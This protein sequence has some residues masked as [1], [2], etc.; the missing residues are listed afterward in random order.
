MI[1]ENEIKKDYT[2]MYR[3]GI[4][5]MRSFTDLAAWLSVIF[6]AEGYVYGL[7]FKK[8]MVSVFL[9]GTVF[10]L[11]F[12]AR[13]NMVNMPALAVSHGLALAGIIFIAVLYD[14]FLRLF[15]YISPVMQFFIFIMIV[16][17]MAASI[18]LWRR[19]FK[20]K[21]YDSRLY[22]LV[23]PGILYTYGAYIARKDICLCGIIFACIMFLAH[24]WSKYFAGAGNVIGN[25]KGLKNVPKD[26]IHLKGRR[27]MTAITAGFLIMIFLAILVDFDYLVVIIGKYILKGIAWALYGMIWLFDKLAVFLS[28]FGID[29]SRYVTAL[30]RIGMRLR[31]G[32]GF[33]NLIM[34]I[35][36]VICI[37]FVLR[38]LL[39]EVTRYFRKSVDEV[40]VD[41]GR[42]S[43]VYQDDLIIDL[44]PPKEDNMSN[45]RTH[46]G[47]IRAM[48][49]KTIRSGFGTRV[50]PGEKTGRE[51]AHMITTDDKSA[52]DMSDIYDR[53][54][55][56]D[57]EMT[58]KDE[59][60]MAGAV[61][62]TRNH[63][64]SPNLD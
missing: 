11:L 30:E 36:G 15:M 27:G 58:G 50:V 47:R 43:V 22:L 8:M 63:R 54:R 17:S 56:G 40:S 53:A 26:A 6:L 51:L 42:R 3:T 13:T 10:F 16:A 32:G 4:E 62:K 38:G 61:R 57:G 60:G 29:S 20:A 25:T 31:N 1:N 41:G 28:R 35:F 34:Q 23:L 24:L 37:Y 19:G 12:A 9:F 33:M 2:G 46:A 59:A 44:E 21:E 48:F 45:G 18:E 64:K 14:R 49:K 5:V 7:D 55:Y 39:R 52:S